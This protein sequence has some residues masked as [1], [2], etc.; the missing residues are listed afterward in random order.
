MSSS[1]PRIVLRVQALAVPD[2]G[3][4]HEPLA[5]LV[6][7]VPCP[8]GRGRRAVSLAPRPLQLGALAQHL[9]WVSNKG[10][11]G[12]VEALSQLHVGLVG[13]LSSHQLLHNPISP[14][15]VL[16]PTVALARTHGQHQ[17][18]GE[19]MVSG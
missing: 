16:A 11:E 8:R 12:S 19:V 4:R 9:R 10:D 2:L 14:L 18:P 6:L 17:I 13:L 5:K 1:S 7:V 15:L 3:P